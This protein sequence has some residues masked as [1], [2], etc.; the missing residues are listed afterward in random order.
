MSAFI[1]PDEDGARALKMV[2]R[3]P[4]VKELFRAVMVPARELAMAQLSKVNVVACG[5]E[6]SQL[7]G[8][9]QF[10]DELVDKMQATGINFGEHRRNDLL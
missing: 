8:V 3:D 7:Q 2:A 10:I 4:A 5:A 9:I 6:A 1:R